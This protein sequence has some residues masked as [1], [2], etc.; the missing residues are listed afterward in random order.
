MNMKPY[1]TFGS[2]LTLDGE[3]NP[4][5]AVGIIY[6]PDLQILERLSHLTSVLAD[7]QVAE[8]VCQLNSAFNKGY[9]LAQKEGAK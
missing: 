4:V 9:D 6:K 7:W 8:I 2:G 5:Y 1:E 3:Q